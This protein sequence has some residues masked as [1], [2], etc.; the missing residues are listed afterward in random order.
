MTTTNR[1]QIT[2]ALIEERLAQPC[3]TILPVD[4]VGLTSQERATYLG[5]STAGRGGA[6]FVELDVPEDL[7]TIALGPKH[8]RPAG[9]MFLA[10]DGPVSGPCQAVRH[11]LSRR[12]VCASLRC[13]L[14]R[15]ANSRVSPQDLHEICEPVLDALD[16]IEGR[17][18]RAQIER[19]VLVI[20]E[21]IVHA[22]ACADAGEPVD[23]KQTEETQQSL[24]ALIDSLGGF[25]LPMT[26][27]CPPEVPRG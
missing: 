11:Q 8:S 15:L 5:M 3:P 27:E 4:P 7:L 6:I 24:L 21:Y 26:A 12:S 9:R 18:L 17:H 25:G 14:D 23:L 22:S 2:R 13:E 16:E 20:N 1:P 19:H 10:V